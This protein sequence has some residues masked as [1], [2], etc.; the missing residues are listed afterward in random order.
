M[1]DRPVYIQNVYDVIT[2]IKDDAAESIRVRRRARIGEDGKLKP[3]ATGVLVEI[4]AV[5]WALMR[6]GYLRLPAERDLEAAVQAF[7]DDLIAND[8]VVKPDDLDDFERPMWDA[9]Q[10]LRAQRAATTEEVPA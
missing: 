10:A 2:T 1:A 5:V 3:G 7:L 8:D 9:L 4:Q 6:G